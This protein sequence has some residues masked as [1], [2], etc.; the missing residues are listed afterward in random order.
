MFRS[1]ILFLSLCLFLTLASTAFALYTEFKSEEFGP[2]PISGGPARWD[3][4]HDLRSA[5]GRRYWSHTGWD[6]WGQMHEE[7]TVACQGNVEAVNQALA[8]FAKIP[9]DEKQIRVFP[10]PGA[11]RSL[12]GKTTVACDWHIHWMSHTS[13][14]R[15]ERKT[16]TQRQTAIMTVYVARTEPIGDSDPRAADWIKDLDDSRF[17]VRQRAFQMLADQREA[18]LPLL[19]LSLKQAASIEQR[20]RLEQ[21]LARLDAIHVRRLVL[22]K[23]IAALMDQE[24]QNWHS[25]NYG[26]SWQAACNICAWAEHTD[27]ALP[28]LVQILLDDRVQA[29]ELALDAFARLGKRAASVVPALQAAQRQAPA[30]RRDGVRQALSSVVQSS[31]IAGVEE[32]WR[33]NRELRK[34]IA[35]F[36]SGT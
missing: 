16:T 31:D 4:P 35:G 8:A 24:L 2:A 28:V 18:A 26:K 36:C 1:W 19:Q 30:A 21:L 17:A 9:A 10:A 25:D 20:M 5:A 7:S 6:G 27:A 29:R 32:G 14:P 13:F 3:R 23:G 12:N 15:G 34:G 11:V 33:R 22:P